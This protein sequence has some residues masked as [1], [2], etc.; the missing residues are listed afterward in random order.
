MKPN[1][2]VMIVDQTGRE[3][4]FTDVQLNLRN[5]AL[6]VH[7]SRA[8]YIFIVRNLICYSFEKEIKENKDDRNLSD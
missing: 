1:R 4:K 5:N 7:T 2:S 8:T 6:E 3:W